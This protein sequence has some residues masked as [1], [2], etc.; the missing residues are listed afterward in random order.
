MISIN[1]IYPILIA[2]L[3]PINKL[4]YCIENSSPHSSASF[5]DLVA[6]AKYFC[7][8][9]KA[10]IFNI[11]D[12][13]PIGFVKNG[14]VDYTRYIQDALNNYNNL[15]FPGFPLLINDNGLKIGSNKTITFLKGSKLILKPSYNGNYDMLSLRDVRNVKIIDPVIVGDRF[16]HLGTKGEWG[17]GIGIYGCTNIT[18][19]NARVSK[20]WGDGIYLGVQNG[21]INRHITLIKPSCINNRRDGFSIIAVDGLIMESPYAGYSNGTL[22]MSGINFEPDSPENEIQN[23]VITNPFTEHNKGQG[24]QIGFDN[25]YGKSNKKVDVKIIKHIDFKSSIGFKITCNTTVRKKNEIIEG[26]VELINP[27]W[28]KNYVRPISTGLYGKDLF[29]LITKPKVQDVNGQELNPEA[30]NKL[31]TFKKNINSNAHY[32]IN[33]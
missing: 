13:L 28:K 23:V 20:C 31:L 17:M 1:L 2:L 32:K 24:I 16:S 5:N 15:L 29:L 6:S 14:T 8:A 33:F 25:L 4:S 9:K 27:H 26:R 22:P 19:V 3:T 21:L 30:V 7:P 18:I 11:E 10:I 12:N